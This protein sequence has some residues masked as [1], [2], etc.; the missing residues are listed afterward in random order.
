MRR[1]LWP[2]LFAALAA[3][4][5]A[6]GIDNAG[7]TGANFL[8]LGSGAGV[9]G[10]GGAAVGGWSDLT[11]VTWNAGSLGMLNES[12]IVF[13]HSPLTGGGAQDWAA[14][15]GRFGS[16]PMRWAANALYQ[17]DGSFEGRDA[18]GNPTGSFGASSM[19]FGATLARAITPNVTLGLGGKMVT[20]KLADASGFGGTF[21]AGVLVHQGDFGFGVAGQNLGGRMKYG[22]AYYSMPTNLGLGVSYLNPGSGLKIALDYNHPSAYYDDVRAG[23]EWTWRDRVALRTG[24]RHEMGGVT[25]DALNGPTFGMG[26]G[27]RGIWFD[28]GYLASSNGDAQ[29]RL[30]LRFSPRAWN[31]GEEM[32]MNGGSEGKR[33]PSMSDKIPPAPKRATPLA[34]LMQTPVETPKTPAPAPKNQAIAPAPLPKSDAPVPVPTVSAAP[35]S[36]A[37]T[38]KTEAVAQKSA[39]APTAATAPKSDAV[40]PKSAPAAKTMAVATKSAPTTKTDAAAPKKEVSAPALAAMVPPP[41]APAPKSVAIK[42]AS[43]PEIAS[44]APAQKPTVA[45]AADTTHAA[46]PTPKPAVAAPEASPSTPAPAATPRPDKVK[47]K[48]GETM[49]SIARQYNTSVAAIMMENNLVSD[50]V[51]VG[52]VLNIP[53]HK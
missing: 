24:Y 38:P 19:A 9:L 2:I 3:R 20:E 23:V 41:S 14:Y 22:N 34:K 15:G 48:A 30:A 18:L 6:A 8:S 50:Q 39:P 16:S 1:I 7:T 37:A 21:D 4:P 40:A 51:K 13:S 45:P 47:V 25:N 28:Y 29:Q 52:Q 32:G 33:A 42:P 26:A 31:G 46:A 35:K 5:A 10:M 43:K 53:K 36:D 49:M 27:V 12:Q 17:G 11:G 44:S